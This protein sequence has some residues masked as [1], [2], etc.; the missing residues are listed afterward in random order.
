MLKCMEIFV[1]HPMVYI[2]TIDICSMIQHTWASQQIKNGEHEEN[3]T[4]YQVAS[5]VPMIWEAHQ[6]PAEECQVS[7]DMIN[8]AQA[9]PDYISE[10]LEP[11]YDVEE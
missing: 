9:I 3:Q 10:G 11:D 4:E 2:E 5:E 7:I 8:Q 1:K 6:P